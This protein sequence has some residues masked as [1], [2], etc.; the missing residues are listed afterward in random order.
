MHSVRPKPLH[1]LCGRPMILHV[2]DAMAEIDVDPGRRGGRA[3]GRVGHQDARATRPA[4]HADRVRRAG[5]AVGH[6]RR[7]GRRA[8][9]PAR[10]RRRGRR[11]RRPPGGH[12]RSCARRRWPR[13]CATTGPPMPARRCSPPK[14]RIPVATAG[15]CTARTTSCAGSSRRSTPPTRRRRSP[16]S[17]RRSTASA[18]ASLAPALRRLSPANAQGEYY[19]TDAV[20][21]LFSAGYRVQSLVLRDPMEAAGRQRPGPAGRG[22]GRAAGSDQRA[23]DAPGRDH[24]GPRAHLCRRRGRSWPPMSRSCRA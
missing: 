7:A 12:A 1:L 10:R 13:W 17:T 24:V 21:V 20:G 14:S 4:L 18:G 2:L 22:R 6:R 3:P 19:L 5:D 16:R 15:S 11:C 9:R 23:L 8:H